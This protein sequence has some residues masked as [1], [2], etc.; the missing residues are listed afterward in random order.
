MNH[1]SNH[2]PALFTLNNPTAP[3]LNPELASEIGLNESILFL[4][5][6]FWLRLSGTQQ[7]DGRY[8]IY[9][10][11]TD[12][13]SIFPFWGRAT[14]N[15]IIHSLEEK[16]LIDVGNFNQYRY[17]KTRWFTLNRTGINRLTSVR[18]FDWWVSDENDEETDL[19]EDDLFQNGTGSDQN[20]TGLFQNGTRSAQNGTTIPDLSSDLSPDLSSEKKSG[21]SAPVPPNPA[22]ER[23]DRLRSNLGDNPLAVAA[24][25][26][27]AQDQAGTIWTVPVEAGGTDSAGDLMADAWIESKELDPDTIPDKQREKWVKAFSK[28]AAP[29]SLSPDQAAEAVEVVLDPYNPEWNWY[30]YSSP[31]VKKFAEDW[32]MVALR[33]LNGGTGYLTTQRRP[34]GVKRRRSSVALVNE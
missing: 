4:Q 7:D 17:D 16:E 24:R 18:I 22:K 25:S 11:V 20:G 27:K 28:L 9:E 14:I 19:A 31:S 30:T 6:E 23:L 15:R 29:L 34:A 26:K 12:I 13:Q 1:K 2:R 33:I 32:T 3:R 10:S 8:W 21:A 5:L